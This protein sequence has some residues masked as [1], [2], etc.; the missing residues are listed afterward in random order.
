M[1]LGEKASLSSGKRSIGVI[2]VDSRSG[3]S[4]EVRG[5]EVLPREEL[6]RQFEERLEERTWGPMKPS[7]RA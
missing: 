1:S 7:A 3:T 2:T 6:E 4:L 5:R